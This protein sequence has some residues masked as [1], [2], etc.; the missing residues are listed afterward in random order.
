MTVESAAS[1]LARKLL[2]LAALFLLALLPRLYSA[3]TLGWDWDSPGSFSLVNFDEGGSCR[4]ALQG[5]PYSTF[6][7]RQTIAIADLLGE[8]P[9]PQIVGDARAVKAYCHSPGHILIARSYSAVS[10][11]LTVVSL[12]VLGLLLVPSRPA[13]GWTAATLLA[14]SGFH[15]SESHSG[16]VDAPSVFFIYTFL[17]LLVYAVRFRRVEALL[18]SPALLVPA[19]WAKYWV[20]AA[21]AYLAVV[22]DRAWQYAVHGMSRGRVVAVVLATALLA[23]MVTNSEFQRANLYPLVL[24][25]YLAIPWRRIH[26]PMAVLW[27]SL[28]LLACL[29]LRVDLIHT[30]TTG[31]QGTA[32]GSGYAAIGWNKLLRNLLN[33]P[34]VVVLGLGLPACLFIPAGC[35]FIA[36]AVASRRA[37]FCLA[38][39]LV[40]ALYMAF[41]A[42]VT[43]YRHYLALIP[44]A[45]LVSACGL[46]STSWASRRWF[47]ALFFTWPA[48][49]AVDVVLDYH[50]DPRIEL[51]QWYAQHDNPRVFASFYVNPPARSRG[52]SPLFRPEYA[53]GDAAILKRANFLILSEN[54]YDT[55]FANELNGPL[56]GNPA[57]LVK[58][59]PEHV[60]FY[61]DALAD[62]HPN[63]VQEQSLRVQNFMPELL[64]H[65]QLYGTFQLFVGDIRILRVVQ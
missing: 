13:V 38:P 33:V 4:A 1:P 52:N 21:F 57:R 15:I 36:G 31:T 25:Y 32:F 19:I 11:A 22:P 40:F 20:F 18:L 6:I 51:R 42:P 28:P 16:T 27:L 37:W 44:A 55:A 53:L 8:G 17:A 64:L 49:L 14:L 5:F 9:A 63:L 43:Y 45:A 7:G 30:Y 50:R 39:L 62:R 60:R 48:L 46:M 2:W 29:V 35:R 41:V 3:Q 65:R 24:L 56:V 61:R 34:T 26:R 58:T 54:W 23:A 47:M 12:A 59:T 10:G